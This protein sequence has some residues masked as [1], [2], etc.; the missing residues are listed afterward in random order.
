MARKSRSAA[1]VPSRE[2]ETMLKELAGSRKATAR[3]VERATVMLADA[4]GKTI[5]EVAPVKRSS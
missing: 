2:Q 1:L 4:A 5:T 3:E